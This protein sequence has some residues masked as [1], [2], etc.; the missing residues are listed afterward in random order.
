LIAAGLD[1]AHVFIAETCTASHPGAFCSYRRDGPPAGRLVG[2]IRAL[3][4]RL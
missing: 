4:P 1:R 2:A 3:R